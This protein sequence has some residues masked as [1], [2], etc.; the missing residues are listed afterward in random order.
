MVTGLDYAECDGY[1]DR[2]RTTR[3]ALV[4]TGIGCT[5]TTRLT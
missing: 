4:A 5:R 3:I 1:K 2:L